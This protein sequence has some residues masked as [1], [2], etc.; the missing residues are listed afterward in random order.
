M[1]DIRVERKGGGHI[2]LWILLAVALLIAAALLLDRAGYVELPINTGANDA[3][4]A[5]AAQLA[6]SLLVVHLQEV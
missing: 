1:A 2:W 4:P 5:S 3:V 6:S